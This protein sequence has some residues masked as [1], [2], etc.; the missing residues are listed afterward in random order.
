M[1]AAAWSGRY[2]R[3]PLLCMALRLGIGGTQDQAPCGCRHQ[4]LACGENITCPFRGL[5]AAVKGSPGKAGL[6]ALAAAA[7]AGGED[8]FVHQTAIRASGFRSL[9]EG[10]AVEFYVETSD[11]GRLKAVEVTGPNGSEPEVRSPCWLP[12]HPSVGC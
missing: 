5:A 7:A 11:D 6:L 9:R 8:L 4:Q 1:Q 2:K 10:A 12:P 3:A